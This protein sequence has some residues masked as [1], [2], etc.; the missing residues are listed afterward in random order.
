[1]NINALHHN[2]NEWQR[3][4]EFLPDRFD[5]TNPLSLTPSG[6]KRNAVCYSPFAGGKRVCF[7]K[8]FAETSLKYVATYV[9]QNFNFEFVNKKFETKF[10]VSHFAMSGRNKVEVILT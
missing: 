8:T 5:H 4:Y 6:T 10:P 3:P 1:M 7:G 9:S 2:A